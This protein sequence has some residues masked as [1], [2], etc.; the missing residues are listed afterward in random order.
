MRKENIEAQILNSC[1]L[2]FVFFRHGSKIG[3]T[4]EIVAKVNQLFTP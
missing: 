4:F 1:P 3:N 2:I